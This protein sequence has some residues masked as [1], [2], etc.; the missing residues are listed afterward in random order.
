MLKI[1]LYPP[2]LF[3]FLWLKAKTL[4]ELVDSSLGLW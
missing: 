1:L 4:P 2:Y 3:R